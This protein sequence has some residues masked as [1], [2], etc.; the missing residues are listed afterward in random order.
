MN[1]SGSCVAQLTC[2]ACCARCAVPQEKDPAVQKKAYKVLAYVCEHRPDFLAAHFQD[3][4]ETV[5]AGARGIVL[6]G[7]A[8]MGS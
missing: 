2:F 8:G 7:G 3:V 1:G 4:L 6:Q 5:V